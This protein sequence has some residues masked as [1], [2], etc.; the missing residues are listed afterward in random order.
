MFKTSLV[1]VGAQRSLHEIVRRLYLDRNPEMDPII[2]VSGLPI[3]RVC[4]LKLEEFE[5]FLKRIM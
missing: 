2:K 1:S 4:L 3:S 5:I